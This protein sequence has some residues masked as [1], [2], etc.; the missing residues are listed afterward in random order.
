MCVEYLLLNRHQV[1]LR[2]VEWLSRECTYFY[3][4]PDELKPEQML[5]RASDILKNRIAGYF[6]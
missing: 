2:Q 5:V 6:L 1:T 4:S 3:T